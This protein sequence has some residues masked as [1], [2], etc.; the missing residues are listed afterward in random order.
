[1]ISGGRVHIDRPLSQYAIDFRA[2]NIIADSVT[3]VIPVP[4]QSDIFTIFDQGPQWRLEKD[5]RAPGTEARKVRY[6]ISS[7]SFY[8]PNY[9]LMGTVTREEMANADPIVV[10]KLEQK[11]VA[12]VRLKLDL[13]REQRLAILMN[14]TCGS[15]T[16]VASVWNDPINSDPISDI[17]TAINNVLFSTGFRPNKMLMPLRVWNQL[18]KHNVIVNKGVNPYV[19]GGKVGYVSREAVASIF[20]LD[21][22]VIGEAFYNTAQEGQTQSLTE[23]WSNSCI[24]YYATAGA[25]TEDPAFCVQFQWHGGMGGGFYVQRHL[26]DTKAGAQDLSVGHYTTELAVGSSFGFALTAAAT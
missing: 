7:A 26:P 23:I 3:P 22:V 10:M 17:N 16:A 5:L 4:N 14:A 1:M 18:R 9:E 11:R 25:S 12:G 24:L 20:E 13:R 19:T 8:C 15:R 6:T 21:E 2:P